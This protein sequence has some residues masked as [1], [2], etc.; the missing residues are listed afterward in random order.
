MQDTPI[1][2]WSESQNQRMFGVGRDLCG[3]S[4]PTLLPKQGHPEQ[5]AQDLVQAGLEYLQRRRYEGTEAFYSVIHV[6]QPGLARSA[7]CA[8]QLGRPWFG[9]IVGGCKWGTT[10]EGQ[11]RPSLLPEHPCVSPANL[12]F[13][14]LSV[15]PI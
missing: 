12:A 8:P 6:M 3:S 7:R 9:E 14:W 15:L 2:R 1:C 13:C 5:A 4:S 11:S 10:W